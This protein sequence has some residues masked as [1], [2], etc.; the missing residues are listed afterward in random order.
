MC[1]AALCKQCTATLYQG[2]SVY[3]YLLDNIL[4]LILYT[5]QVTSCDRCAA[6][7]N[8]RSRN[9]CQDSINFHESPFDGHCL[10]LF[11]YLSTILILILRKQPKLKYPIHH[12]G[13]TVNGGNGKWKWKAEMESGNGKWSSLQ[14][15]KP[16][17]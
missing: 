11:H 6:V 12:D 10:T 17:T 14:K 7:Y 5:S 3:T 15:Y 16:G 9:F 2:I 1:V 13:A 8:F 4:Q